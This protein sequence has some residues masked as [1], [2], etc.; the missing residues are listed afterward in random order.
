MYWRGRVLHGVQELII[1]DSLLFTMSFLDRINIGTA[2]LAGLTTD[3][4][5]TSLQYNTA[6]MSKC[7]PE[8]FCRVL[9][10]NS[11]DQKT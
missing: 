8:R 6:S 5:L 9:D 11:R 10:A 4:G 2:K 7:Y 3:L 1:Y